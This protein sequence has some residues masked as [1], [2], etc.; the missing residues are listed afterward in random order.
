VDDQVPII[1]KFE[2]NDLEEISGSV[3]P[4]NQHLGRIRVGF[5]IDGDQGMFECMQR[6]GI[7]DAVTACR[8]VDLHTILS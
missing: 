2:D 3:R 4:D 1:G 6:V 7:L 8:P 5:E